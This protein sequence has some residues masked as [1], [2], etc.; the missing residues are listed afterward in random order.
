MGR[1]TEAFIKIDTQKAPFEEKRR[2]IQY[3]FVIIST[4]NKNEASS[5]LCS[6][7]QVLSFFKHDY[8]SIE[9]L[10]PTPVRSSLHHINSL[11]I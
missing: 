11:T 5:Q 3:G 9:N 2:G 6:C 10:N 7:S 1:V 4:V 8:M